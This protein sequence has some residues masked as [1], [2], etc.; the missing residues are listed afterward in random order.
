[1]ERGTTKTETS[2][3]GVHYIDRRKGRLTTCLLKLLPLLLLLSAGVHAAV[4]GDYEYA[5]HGGGTCIITDYI[6]PGAD[7]V[8]P[9][10]LDGLTVVEIGDYAFYDKD[11]LTGIT[12]PDSVTIIWERA[13]YSCSNL[14]NLS[15]GNSITTIGL[16][17][18]GDCSSLTGSLV[19]PDSVTTIET[20]AFGGCTSLTS[21]IIDNGT[22]GDSA[23]A[24]CSSLADVTIGDS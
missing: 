19:I 14:S 20:R 6:G 22:I 23:F 18:F 3:V 10:M 9:N 8:I 13:F 21:V 2:G 11:V 7:V 4:S 1:M 12:I 15:I 16:E 5:D 24:Y 17:A